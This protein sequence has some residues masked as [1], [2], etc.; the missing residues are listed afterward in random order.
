MYIHTQR[1]QSQLWNARPAAATRQSK[2]CG[3]PM[4]TDSPGRI[5]AQP[6]RSVC[7]CA[8]DSSLDSNA[9]I[10][11]EIHVSDIA[12]SRPHRHR[13]SPQS[14]Y[15]YQRLGNYSRHIRSR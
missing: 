2:R 15:Q 11:A 10:R 8:A 1:N 5:D 4:Q 3:L 9:T 12:Y 6:P 13:T 14:D 7:P